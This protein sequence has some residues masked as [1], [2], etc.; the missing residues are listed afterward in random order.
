MMGLVGTVVQA[1]LR[2]R[3]PSI[4]PE[5]TGKVG[6]VIESDSKGNFCNRNTGSP[7]KFHGFGNAVL[8]DKLPGRHALFSFECPAELKRTQA[9]DASNIVERY[10]F[11]VIRVD[12]VN[13]I[14]SNTFF[15]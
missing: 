3:N 1:V 10:L 9:A 11:R 2:R 15:Y 14:K 12:I 13:S 7:Q 6:K 4:L 8:D 5:P